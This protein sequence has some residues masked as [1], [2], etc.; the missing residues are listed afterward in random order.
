MQ[1]SPV[2]SEMFRPATFPRDDGQAGFTLIEVIAVLVIAAL[3]AG[4]L[5]FGGRTNGT[6]QLKAHAATIAAGLRHVRGRAISRGREIVTRID[7]GRSRISWGTKRAPL[8]L[9]REIGLKATTAQSETGGHVAGIRFF[10]N[11]SSTGGSLQLSSGSAR[12]VIAV[13]WLTGGVSIV[14]AN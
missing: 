14:R 8:A 6:A 2:G 9:K 10:P 13:N 4:S 3:M 5:A 11:G 1:M 12:F 7:I